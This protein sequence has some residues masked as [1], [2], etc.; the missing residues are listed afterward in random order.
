MTCWSVTCQPFAQSPCSAD[1]YFCFCHIFNVALTA[2]LSILLILSA[3]STFVFSSKAK[4]FFS[5]LT[6]RFSSVSSPINS[7]KS[8]C[9]R[10][11]KVSKKS[12]TPSV[13]SVSVHFSRRYSSSF[14]LISSKISVVS[15]LLS[16]SICSKP[17]RFQLDAIEK[18]TVIVLNNYSDIFCQFFLVKFD[19]F[20]VFSAKKC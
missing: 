9:T 11:V 1:S 4:I 3:V 14:L 20:R 16:A 18:L 5:A 2:I 19:F 8:S 13:E 10:L 17:K 7:S 12:K 15:T 6:N